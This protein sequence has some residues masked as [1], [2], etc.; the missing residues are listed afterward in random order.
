MKL[1]I[2]LSRKED[3]RGSKGPLQAFIIQEGFKGPNLLSKRSITNIDSA[4]LEVR[5]K[6]HQ[7]EVEFLPFED[8][9]KPNLNDKA[10]ATPRDNYGLK[11][12]GP[13]PK[14]ANGL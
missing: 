12:T 6:L 5:S 9:W 2:K 13:A 4:K 11:G 10:V 1:Q 7:H 8:P 14:R 3:Y